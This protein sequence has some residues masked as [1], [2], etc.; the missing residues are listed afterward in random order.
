MPGKIERDDLELAGYGIIVE[1]M[2]ILAAIG[3]GG[4]QA[5]QRHAATCLF[6]VNTIVEA[7]K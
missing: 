2:A 4:V 3:A 6:N 5:Q 7:I 1:Q